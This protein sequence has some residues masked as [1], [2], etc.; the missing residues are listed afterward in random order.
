MALWDLDELKIYHSKVVDFQ[1]V[2][3][4]LVEKLY[5]KID[6]VPRYVL[7]TPMKVCYEQNTLVFPV[8]TSVPSRHNQCA[9]N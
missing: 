2:P 8:R 6:G 4:R 3:L 5:L 7:E 9:D 1:V